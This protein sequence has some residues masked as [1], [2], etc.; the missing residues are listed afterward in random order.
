MPDLEVNTFSLNQ[1]AQRLGNV[2]RRITN[3][4]WRL[5]SLYGQVGLLD[6]WN[7]I[8]ADALTGYS[9][10]ILMCQSYLTQTASDFDAVENKLLSQDPTDFSK[11]PV[12]GI[13]EVIYDVGVGIKKV[14]RKLRA[15][16]KKLSQAHLIATTL[17]EQYIKLFNTGKQR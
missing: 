16:S 1:Y 7:L 13:K 3:L 10:R 15:L 5:K 9:V 6:L 2:N 14:L 11:P 17:T 12:S 8:R 4:D